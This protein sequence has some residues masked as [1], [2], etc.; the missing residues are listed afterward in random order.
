MIIIDDFSTQFI[1]SFRMFLYIFDCKSL[2]NP[3]PHSTTDFVTVFRQ[4]RSRLFG[5]NS[6]SFKSVLSLDVPES[7]GKGHVSPTIEIS[8]HF[9]PGRAPNP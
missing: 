5:G 7:Y 1:T 2:R 8:I 3:N 6:M 9:T 4:R